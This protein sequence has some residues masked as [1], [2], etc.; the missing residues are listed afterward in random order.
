MRKNQRIK[1]NTEI[2]AVLQAKQSIGGSNFVVYKK[3]NHTEE[4]RFALSVSKKYGI[5][6]KR[7]QMKRRIR[8]IVSSL[9]FK[10]GFDVFVIAKNRSSSLSFISIK[11]ELTELFKKAQLLEDTHE[12]I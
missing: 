10:E 5:A 1:K 12:Q 4:T 8:E 11:Q 9:S 3:E 7:N 6:V 2:Q